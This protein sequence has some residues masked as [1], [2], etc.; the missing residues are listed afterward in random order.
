MAEARFTSLAGVST[1]HLVTSE[2]AY[3]SPS[4]GWR[5]DMPYGRYQI[6]V[7]AILNNEGELE[8]LLVAR[9]P[10]RAVKKYEYFSIPPDSAP[11]IIYPHRVAQLLGRS[12][13]E[14]RN[15]LARVDVR[16]IEHTISGTLAELTE[17]GEHLDL[18]YPSYQ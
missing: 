11:H 2:R 8:V 12:R 18:R 10:N 3:R 5:K 7:E 6:G 9:V 1:T 14:F 15:R 13:V 4:L 17:Y 16:P